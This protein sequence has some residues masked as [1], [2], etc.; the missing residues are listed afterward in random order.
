VK[1]NPVTALA[2]VVISVLVIAAVVVFMQRFFRKSGRDMALIRTG[3]GGQRVVLDGGVLCLPFLHRVDEISM[4]TQKMDV[5]RAGEKSLITEDRLR[6]DVDM[7][8]HVRVLPT[9]QGVA[10]A[11]QAFGAKMLRSEELRGLLEGRFVDALQAVVAVHS[12]DALHDKRAAVVRAVKAGLG[13]DMTSHGLVLESVSLVRLDQTPLAGLNENNAFNAQGMRRLAEIVANHKM[14]RTE[15]EAEADLSVRQTALN[16][17]KNKLLIEQD[18]QQAQLSQ[19]LVL[20]QARAKA[21]TEG[22]QARELAQR[23][24]DEARIARE[25]HTKTAEVARDL[26]LDTQ[27]LGAQ[28]SV[29]LLRVE[30]S[31]ALSQKQSE[32]A[33]ATV[34]AEQAKTQVVLAQERGHTERERVVQARALESAEHRSAQEALVDAAKLRL[35][36]DRLLAHANAQAQGQQALIAAENTSTEALLAH[37]L[38]LHKLNRL[39]ELA[40]QMVKPLEKIESIRI[41]HLG[42]FGPQATGATAGNATPVNQIMNGVMDMALQMPLLKRLG[43][44]IGMD[45]LSDFEARNQSDSTPQ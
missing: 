10:T 32:E 40:A 27:R 33:A 23:S 28:L 13:D 12:M 16:L 17:T 26:F 11:A 14:R 24:T 3:V 7:E 2:L 30:Q 38:A 4:R 22:A 6:V 21:E 44:S 36:V 25:Q 9:P 41:N 1:E 31:V 42:G 45:L 18:E 34:L 15:I 37:K 35:E 19:R 8:F 39:P 43:E 5:R 20:E 29:E